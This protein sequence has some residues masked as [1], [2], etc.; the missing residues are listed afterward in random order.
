MAKIVAYK[1][2][3][4]GG[5]SV[6]S[7]GGIA[8]RNQL[9]GV[10][11][12]GA[13]TQSLAN[14]LNDITKINN[15]FKRTE[16]EIEKKQRRKLQRERDNAAEERQEGKS[17]EKGKDPTG[18]Y[19]KT[20]KRGKPKGL[21]KGALGMKNGF[22]GFLS[23]FLAPIAGLV[24]KL[25]AK[26]LF[27]AL[28]KYLSDPKK[29]EEVKVFIEKSSFVFTK[30]WEFGSM[31][32]GGVMDTVGQ[33]VGKESTLVERLVGLGK[34][35]GAITGITLALQ[36]V[37]FV[38]D[39]LGLVDTVEDVADAA[40]A[41]NDL[42]RAKNQR[43]VAKEL[44]EQLGENAGKIA[45]KRYR[46][47]VE[48]FGDEAAEVFLDTMKKT[49][50]LKEANKAVNAFRKTAETVDT[51][52]DIAKG[53]DAAGDVPAKPGFFQKMSQRIAERVDTVTQSARSKVDE[54]VQFASKGLKRATKFVRNFNFEDFA[55]KLPKLNI[56]LPKLG[57]IDGLKSIP[58]KAAKRYQQI[59]EG[60]GTIYKNVRSALGGI[61]DNVGS[62]L[63]KLGAGARDIFL[64][65]VYQR[66]KP[67]FDGIYG[68]IKP[69]GKNFKKLLFKIPGMEKAGKVLSGMGID[70]LPGL[71]KAGSGKIG[72]R[73][74]S[75]LPLVGS[76][77]NFLFAYQRLSQGDTIGALVEGTSGAIQFSG[78]LASLTGVGLGPG[79][80]L[81]AASYGGDAYMFL[82]D[83]IPEIQ[84]TEEK[85]VNGMGLGG[86]KKFI[87]EAYAKVLPGLGTI[88]KAMSG[89]LEGAKK[90]H[91][92]Q[93]NFM[94]HG[95]ALEARKERLSEE[96]A[97]RNLEVTEKGEIKE[98]KT[99]VVSNQMGLMEMLNSGDRNL[100]SNA[101]FQMRSNARTSDESFSDFDGNPAYEKDIDIILNNP[102]GY[103]I[104][105]GRPTV[106]KKGETIE[107]DL[108]FAKGGLVP[109]VFSAV[110]EKA[111]DVLANTDLSQKISIVKGMAEQYFVPLVLNQL[112]PMPTPVPINSGGGKVAK[113]S[114]SITR[115]L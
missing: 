20:L 24:Q 96:N 46:Y 87:D 66:F 90:M 49:G 65:Q 27:F 4:P 109:G 56:K 62:G 107:G 21:L 36:G 89:D 52:K 70:G 9:L 64:K 35:V 30:L 3:N 84:E 73:A 48:E 86:I 72:A 69:I 68:V 28:L 6:R 76:I 23:G 32:V 99:T 33:V 67:F 61:M 81:T 111:S 92:D 106:V 85:V 13:S 22:F 17:V 101:L 95:T 14:T 83:F 58:E 7:S 50:D 57:I 8:A 1:F 39:A 26:A 94:G 10:N 44:A 108:D 115:R 98:T 60:A 55:S 75:F 40:D 54:G 47:I 11:R 53:L 91:A 41:A 15:A 97:D 59:A 45:S 38:R 74:N 31:L 79:A 77:A 37:N 42:R 88:M 110:K 80:I 18:E 103:S 12:I 25:M 34:I 19:T 93:S 63:A 112:T 5:G 16:T 29:T 2:V 71:M 113:V 43:K 104:S 100:I 51:A 105:N 82:R 102:N 78:D 114:T